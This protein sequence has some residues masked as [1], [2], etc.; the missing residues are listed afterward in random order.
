VTILVTESSVSKRRP[1]I[2][3][4]AQSSLPKGASS[5]MSPSSLAK[6]QTGQL[7]TQGGPSHDST[8]AVTDENEVLAEHGTWTHVQTKENPILAARSSLCMS[9]PLAP[10]S[11]RRIEASSLGRNGGSLAKA[12]RLLA[13]R[14]KLIQS[15]KT[16]KTHN[17]LNNDGQPS[18]AQEEPKLQLQPQPHQLPDSTSTI[19][20]TLLSKNNDTVV[21]FEFVDQFDHLNMS[22]SSLGPIKTTALNSIDNSVDA[23]RDSDDSTS[24]GHTVDSDNRVVPSMK[25]LDNTTNENGEQEKQPA[26][27]FSKELSAEA[28]QNVL[29]EEEEPQR[30]DYWSLCY[31]SKKDEYMAQTQTADT[32]PGLW[33]ARRLPPTKS[34]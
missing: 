34:W 9:T 1:I 27:G 26:E 5:R 29:D 32:F 13:S 28:V 8:T 20:H 25:A 31:G 15:K 12:K 19:Q 18:S 11:Q 33:S 21:Q 14:T 23:M 6:K 3:K 17:D 22:D 4:S 7:T 30:P 16:K 10:S 24:K 2:I